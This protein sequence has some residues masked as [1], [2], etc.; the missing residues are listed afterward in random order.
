LYQ[1]HNERVV[2]HLIGGLADLLVIDC[3][4]VEGGRAVGAIDS[5]IPALP[6]KIRFGGGTACLEFLSDCRVLDVV[7]ESLD[8]EV[9]GKSS[10]TISIS[11]PAVL[12][13]HVRSS[14]GMAHEPSIG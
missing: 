3:N 1:F 7:E 14:R 12:N 9:E 2:A 6:A 11:V 10:S 4:P 13:G 8:R 5:I